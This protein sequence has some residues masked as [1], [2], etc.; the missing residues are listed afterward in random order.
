[1]KRFLLILSLLLPITINAKP[2][3]HCQDEQ[4]L[5]VLKSAFASQGKATNRIMNVKNITQIKETQVYPEKGIRSCYAVVNMVTMRYLTDYSIVLTEH[6]FFVQVENAQP[7][8][9]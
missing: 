3:Y 5:K 9:K 7:N 1:M 4:V 2:L 6:G 8:D